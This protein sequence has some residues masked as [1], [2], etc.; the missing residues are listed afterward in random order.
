MNPFYKVQNYSK[1]KQGIRNQDSILFEGK[2]EG[3]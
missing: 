1:L 2:I 3:Q